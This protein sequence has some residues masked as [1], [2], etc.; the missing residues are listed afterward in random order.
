MNK[1][2]IA[3]IILSI[4]NIWYWFRQ[5]NKPWDYCQKCGEKL[6]EMGYDDKMKCLSCDRREAHENE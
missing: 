1:Y 4:F 2:L 3:A 6:S 5:A